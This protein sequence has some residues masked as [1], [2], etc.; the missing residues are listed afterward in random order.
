MYIVKKNN[1]K[2]VRQVF[3]TYDEARSHVR[4]M[5]RKSTPLRHRQLA[6]WSD[7]VWHTPTLGPFGYS[8]E[9]L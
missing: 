6:D 7:L 2:T 9:K 4:K 5:I 3:D 1:K 8:I